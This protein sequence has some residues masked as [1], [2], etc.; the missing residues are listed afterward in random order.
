MKLKKPNS[1]LAIAAVGAFLSFSSV[2]WSQTAAQDAASAASTDTSNTTG[3]VSGDGTVTSTGHCTD[4]TT[5]STAKTKIACEAG[6]GTW[7]DPSVQSDP[8]DRT[9]PSKNSNPKKVD[10]AVPGTV[11]GN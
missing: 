7:T 4:E 9:R 2:G 6:G 8:L 11:D 1:I 10:P 3:T 5:A